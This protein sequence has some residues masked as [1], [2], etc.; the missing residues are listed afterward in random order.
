MYLLYNA[1]KRLEKCIN[2]IV[3]Q[4]FNDIEII[5]VNDGS[6]DCSLDICNKYS[7]RDKR[8]RVINKKN[9]G[10][11]KTRR[12]GLEVS[13]GEF[14][15]FVDADDWVDSRFVE[16][17]YKGVSE[18]H[19]DVAVCNMY[20][21][22]HTAIL[23]RKNS[24]NYFSGDRIY[25]GDEIKNQLVTAWFHGHPFPAALCAKIYKRSILINSGKYLDRIA[26]LG[27]DLFCN[28]EI[29]NK[30]S[31]VKVINAPLYYY[32]VGGFTGKY[33]PNHFKDIT[34]G[35]EIQKDVIEKYYIDSKDKQYR[36]ISIMLLNSFKSSLQ[37]IMESGLNDKKIKET[38]EGYTKDEN[39][40]EAI[41]NEG[42]KKYVEQDFLNAIKESDVDYLFNI[43]KQ[44]SNK[45]KKKRFI[46][47]IVTK[48]NIL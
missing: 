47:N 14:I 3:N 4:I 6:T 35:Y 22:L 42:S 38:I 21:V 12:R 2:S 34:N 39:I 16:T 25:E 19:C 17:L 27:E 32:R 8:I 11:I 13:N 30:A 9:E 37:N 40:L 33:M 45:S 24:S 23:K 31:R 5:L 41:S 36:G 20:R 7:V 44:L 18:N 48:F 29:F 15:V 10:C 1:G 46:L 28:I 26:F 43:G